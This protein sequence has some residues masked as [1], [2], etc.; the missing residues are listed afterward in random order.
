[1]DKLG[2]SASPR[3]QAA[4]SSFQQQD[5]MDSA[6]QGSPRIRA[7]QP[8]GGSRAVPRSQLR[9][10]MA[11]VGIVLAWWALQ[12]LVCYCGTAGV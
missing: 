1:M 5:S 8:D 12:A 7:L 11:T 4:G 9:Q 6:G 2:I 10:S 3:T